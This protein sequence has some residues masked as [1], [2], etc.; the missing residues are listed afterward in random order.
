[1]VWPIDRGVLL[2]VFDTEMLLRLFFV[3]FTCSALLI[4][5][6]I[7]SRRRGTTATATPT[8]AGGVPSG[9]PLRAHQSQ[10]GPVAAATGSDIAPVP[11]EVPESDPIA[12]ARHTE[13]ATS[14]ER[15][16]AFE[17]YNVFISY[18]RDMVEWA[19]EAQMAIEAFDPDLSALNYR[20]ID[21][22]TIN[23]GEAWQDLIKAPSQCGAALTIVLFGE[24]VGLPL[25]VTFRQRADIAERLKRHD[26]D[27]I[28]VPGVDEPKE[29]QVPLTGVLFELF[30]IL[31]ARKER[32]NAG[33]LLVVFRGTYS[34]RSGANF[35]SGAWEREILR[36][37]RTRSSAEK[38]A[39]F[40]DYHEQTTQLEIV[41]GQL[42]GAGM[43][44]IWVEEE[45]EFK[46]HVRRRL[47]ETFGR[48]ELA[49]AD[50]DLPGL[51]PYDQKHK[52]VYFPRA[53]E[54][55]RLFD[56]AFRRDTSRSFVL[57]L[58]ES[59]CGKSSLL[60]AG[61]AA[62]ARS[63]AGRIRGW[64]TA[65]LS[66][67]DLA[68]GDDPVRELGNAL[69]HPDA[70]PHV[71]PTNDLSTLL[72][73]GSRDAAIRL[74]ER[75]QATQG[76]AAAAPGAE[77]LRVM[78]LI[79]QMEVALDNARAADGRRSFDAFLE[80]V[81]CLGGSARSGADADIR[82]AALALVAQVPV[83]VVATLPLY[84]LRDA[85]HWLVGENIQR[86]IVS[87]NLIPAE[88]AQIF[89][90]TLNGLR[91][92]F[93]RMGMR[94]LVD[95]CAALVEAGSILPLVAVALRSLQDRWITR[96]RPKAGLTVDDL[97]AH[98]RIEH[99]IRSLGESA[100]AE[101]DEMGS[102]I[103]GQIYSLPIYGE[104]LS[105]L[106]G[107]RSAIDLAFARLM[108]R[109]VGMY[110]APLD[111]TLRDAVL[112][113]LAAPERNVAGPLLKKRLLVL[114]RDGSVRLAHEKV[115]EAW[116]RAKQWR[117]EEDQDLRREAD[118]RREGTE[119]AKERQ[120]DDKQAI[121]RRLGLSDKQWT[122]AFDLY[123]RRGRDLHP[124]AREF[125]DAC[126]RF[127][128]EKDQRFTETGLIVAA[129]VGDTKIVEILSNE[130][131]IN[132]KT[133]DGASALHLA[134]QNGH[135]EVARALIVKGSAVDSQTDSGFTPLHLAAQNGHDAIAELLITDKRVN[136][137][138]ETKEGG[139]PLHLAS[140]FGHDRVVDQLATSGAK[141]DVLTQKL[142]TPLH[143]AAQHGHDKVA[144]V[145]IKHG[146]QLE[147]R[148][149]SR[150]TALHLAVR[151]GHP[152][153]VR[154]LLDARADMDARTVDNLT[155]LLLA[156]ESENIEIASLLVDRGAHLLVEGGPNALE[157]AV[158]CRNA[159][160][161]EVLLRRADE[162][163][164]S[165]L[166]QALFE[167]V[168]TGQEVLVELLL[169]HKVDPNS[170]SA[171]EGS[172]LMI[173]VREGH[174]GAARLL[175]E[176]GA[177]V[178]WKDQ[179]SRTALHWACELGDARVTGLLLDK[180]ANK[181]WQDAD[182]MT[183]LHLAVQS[184]HVPL[185]RLLASAGADLKARNSTG[186]DPLNLA[187]ELERDEVASVLREFAGLTETDGGASVSR[188]REAPPA[189]VVRIIR[190][191]R[192]KA[193]RAEAQGSLTV[194]IKRPINYFTAT[195]RLD[196]EFF[197]VPTTREVC[198]ISK[199]PQ[200]PETS[201][202]SGAGERHN[203]NV[204]V[205][206]LEPYVDLPQGIY[207]F[208]YYVACSR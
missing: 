52:E 197:E 175:L 198:L 48:G 72:S 47:L 141:V 24:R 171:T 146:A 183:P 170:V 169:N 125:L 54:R 43:T 160:L 107:H 78:L 112:E 157:L 71:D 140:G 182:Y 154:L 127:R 75:V 57:L 187:V 103:R 89:E 105:V 150:Q 201:I 60:R 101:I 9:P 176:R 8:D 203:F 97:R 121:E 66:L 69:R 126:L 74:V 134:T 162:L 119:L 4:L 178:D 6:R 68:T 28:Y 15:Q 23:S 129:S 116:P 94:E 87:A 115:L 37:A 122:A 100:W 177:A 95:E 124:E 131:T 151:N 184:G 14:L 158:R 137:N 205:K 58:G 138:A 84:R 156:V 193:T 159:L 148:T 165:A 86:L 85:D 142:S 114:K 73:A 82:N 180:G 42:F 88:I 44:C 208:N 64:R 186:L 189:A 191:K 1:M 22:A 70:L 55:K 21:P 132:A 118:L 135:L 39:L 110:G 30:D 167:A 3:V 202:T 7:W 76:K 104:T 46:E 67:T 108:R 207:V 45:E 27:W 53:A 19:Y 13:A 206:S 17:E 18:S 49:A 40:A 117:G 173:A 163:G 2:D 102:E 80:L 144:R 172:A 50:I 139:T 81:G 62:R 26:F 63:P 123:A 20:D 61:L 130:A 91:I 38:K 120:Q 10:E 133:A 179:R 16:D 41:R 143:L 168:R 98:G 181:N 136:L 93:D 113:Q 174:F 164:P 65:L 33:E 25:P 204:H 200:T 59:G 32:K 96:G 5:A 111:I 188:T 190:Q 192:R 194:E 92:P 51:L 12:S 128:A 199:P 35:G 109:L 90:G 195:G 196:P 36:G 83:T 11:L 99:A 56:A 166:S 155:P 77:R 149:D 106:R 34:E 152:S 145:L 147:S 153:V 185:V 79:D 31:I 29:G 161:L